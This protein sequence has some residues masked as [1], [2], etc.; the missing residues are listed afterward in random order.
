MRIPLN[1]S[2]LTHLLSYFLCIRWPCLQTASIPSGN[3]LLLLP[4]RVKCSLFSW[5]VDTP[6]HFI[7]GFSH[8][9]RQLNKHDA[10]ITVATEV[11]QAYVAYTYILKPAMWKSMPPTIVILSFACPWKPCH[12][13]SYLLYRI[14]FPFSLLTDLT[15]PV[16]FRVKLC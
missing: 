13:D 10:H 9:C 2:L 6:L 7:S 4:G 1:T 5:A 14:H 11:S 8:I 12:F 3:I 16:R 15:L